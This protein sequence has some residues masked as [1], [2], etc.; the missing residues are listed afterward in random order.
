LKHPDR[1][2][3]IDIVANAFEQNPRAQAMMKKKNP[4]RSVRL[5]TEYAYDLVEKFNGIYISEDKT[6]V[7]FYYLNSQYRRSL[8]D[9]LKYCIMFFRVN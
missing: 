5:M 7:L 8:A 2:I 9:Y 4:A 3:I 6:T 1:D